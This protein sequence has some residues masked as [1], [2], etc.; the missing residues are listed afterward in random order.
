[1]HACILTRCNAAKSRKWEISWVGRVGRGEK[2][3]GPGGGGESVQGG[4]GGL[5]LSEDGSVSRWIRR[6]DSSWCGLGS[7]SFRWRGKVE[8]AI[9]VVRQPCHVVCGII[10]LVAVCYMYCCLLCHVG[11]WCR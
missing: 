7:V 9:I 3:S 4:N 10:I 6:V 11:S 8:I 5:G 2:A 1:M